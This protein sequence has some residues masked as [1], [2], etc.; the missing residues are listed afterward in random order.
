MQRSQSSS[1]KD[2]FTTTSVATKIASDKT[3]LSMAKSNVPPLLTLAP[4]TKKTQGIL[5]SPRVAHFS[6]DRV[7]HILSGNCKSS[8]SD[9]VQSEHSTTDAVSNTNV[10]G[11]VQVYNLTSGGLSDANGMSFTVSSSN[12]RILPLVSTAQIH[13]VNSFLE[14]SISNERINELVSSSTPTK[15]MQN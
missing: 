8:C 12:S 1:S 3:L 15:G 6:S 14:H 5:S 4:D 9:L 2:D 10:S 13:N 7:T 11:N